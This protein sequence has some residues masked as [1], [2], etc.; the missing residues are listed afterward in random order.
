MLWSSNTDVVHL[1]VL[2]DADE[3]KLEI[4]ATSVFVSRRNAAEE[5]WGYFQ[6]VP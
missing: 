2:C 1:F 5:G 4:E 3:R 6:E